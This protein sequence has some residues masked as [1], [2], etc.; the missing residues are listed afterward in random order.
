MCDHHALVHW[1]FTLREARLTICCC[2]AQEPDGN[3]LKDAQETATNIIERDFVI[4]SVGVARALPAEGS[5]EKAQTICAVLIKSTVVEYAEFAMSCVRSTSD[6]PKALF[7]AIEALAPTEKRRDR[8]TKFEFMRA[9]DLPYLLASIDSRVRSVCKVCG[10]ERSVKECM[11][12]CKVAYCS[13]QCQRI[14]WRQGGHK[15]QC[16]A[17]REDPFEIMTRYWQFVGEREPVSKC[18]IDIGH[19]TLCRETEDTPEGVV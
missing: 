16:A 18:V 7:M 19:G 3:A 9:T 6:V 4:C 5:C 10:S 2:A 11:N 14:D 8:Q 1:R 17:L 13:K 15:T 12:C